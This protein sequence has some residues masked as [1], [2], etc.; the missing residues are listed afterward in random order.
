M[1]NSPIF[2]IGVGRSGTTLIRQMINSHSKIAVPYESHFITKYMDKISDYGG[3]QKDENLMRLLQD[4]CKEPI[5]DNWDYYCTPEDLMER[6]TQ[7]DVAN[8]FDAFYSLYAEHHGKRRWADKSDYLDRMYQIKELYPEAKFIHIIRDGRDVANSVMKMTWGPK[9]LI[10]AADWWSTY[11]RLCYSMGRMLSPKDYMEV[12]Y[13]D[14]VTSSEDELKRI[15]EFI[16]VDFEEPMLEFYKTSK[17]FIPQSLLNQHYNADTP[18]SKARTYAWKKEM[19]ES[20]NIIFQQIA[21]AVLREFN[22]ECTDK[23]L[24]RFEV[25]VRKLPMHVKSAFGS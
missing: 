14:L 3:L 17:K 16:E 25:I 15:C 21:G 13:E 24:P 12:R 18:P 5:L 10:Q 8:I 11:V 22:Y 23:K 20:D 9:N 6:I 7:R 1:K 4:I 2:I 19:S